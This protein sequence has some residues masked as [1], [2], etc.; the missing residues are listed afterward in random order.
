M[1]LNANY[2]RITCQNNGQWS[3]RP[4]CVDPNS[5]PTTRP[6][7]PTTTTKAPSCGSAPRVA[8][9]Y[10]ITQD[11]TDPISR[12]GSLVQ[13]GCSTGFKINGPSLA[14]C[15]ANY[16]WTEVPTCVQE[17]I[18]GKLTCGEPPQVKSGRLVQKTYVG[19][20]FDGDRVTYQCDPGFIAY[21]N[22]T[23]IVCLFDGRWTPEPLCVLGTNAGTVGNIQPVATLST[24]K[25]S[26]ATTRQTTTRRTTTTTTVKTE[27]SDACPSNPPSIANAIIRMQQFKNPLQG[28]REG[29]LAFYECRSGYQ[30]ADCLSPPCN[31]A[32]CTE[33][34]WRIQLQCFFARF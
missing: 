10:I 27:F 20:P 13:Y 3:T 26:T 33:N 14:L 18:D 21:Q 7:T 24:T 12:Y 30:A 5:V 25:T 28:P 1:F 2:R 34:A 8:N 4:E 17:R 16:R 32:I 11:F 23:T 31:R 22:K 29:D 19:L 9:G 6:T 15:E